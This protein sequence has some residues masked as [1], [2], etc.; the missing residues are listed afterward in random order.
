MRYNST[1][2]LVEKMSEITIY[3]SNSNCK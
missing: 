1:S 2:D 3:R